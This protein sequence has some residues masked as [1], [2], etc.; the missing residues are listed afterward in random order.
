MVCVVIGCCW[1][2]Y[3]RRQYQPYVAMGSGYYDA[4]QLRYVAPQPNIAMNQNATV[5]PVAPRPQQV[6][7]VPVAVTATGGGQAQAYAGLPTVSA[8]RI[9]SNAQPTV[10]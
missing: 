5:N 9:P 1:G 10:Q 3:R 7:V 2:G 6:G 8:K 4:D